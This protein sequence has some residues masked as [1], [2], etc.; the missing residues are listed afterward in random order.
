MEF[1]Q[2]DWGQHDIINKI[3]IL[4]KQGTHTIHAVSPTKYQKYPW[5]TMFKYM[6]VWAKVNK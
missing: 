1:I 3:I 5:T 4:T 2:N 6:N